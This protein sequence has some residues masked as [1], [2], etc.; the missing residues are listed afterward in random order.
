MRYLI[1]FLF[2]FSANSYSFPVATDWV[3]TKVISKGIYTDPKNFIGKTQSFGRNEVK[4][5]FYNCGFGKGSVANYTTYYDI[6]EFLSNKEFKTFLNNRSKLN[7]P[8]NKKIYVEKQTC[9]DTG[10]V[11][12]PFIQIEGEKNAY[13]EFDLGIFELIQK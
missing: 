7:M 9:A 4:G 10:S 1:I 5:P 13:Y 6:D 12:F 11:L 2:L 8:K 3:V